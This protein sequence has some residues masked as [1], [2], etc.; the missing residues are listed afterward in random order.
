MMRFIEVWT[1][2]SLRCALW[3]ILVNDPAV[4]AILLGHGPCQWHVFVFPRRTALEHGASEVTVVARR[5]GTICPKA[6]T[7][8]SEQQKWL[9]KTRFGLSPSALPSLQVHFLWVDLTNILG[10]HSPLD[11]HIFAPWKAIDYLNFVKPW[12]EKYKHDTQT[13]VKQFLRWKQLYEASGC[14]VPECWPKQVKH[15]GHTISVSDIWFIA[16]HMK[17]LST[18]TGNSAPTARSL[19]RE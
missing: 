10:A 6:R 13:N 7:Q 14:Q 17:K 8:R 5:H 11:L 12:D 16:H 18:K 19:G 3:L 9:K 4:I 1:T 2:A 15:D